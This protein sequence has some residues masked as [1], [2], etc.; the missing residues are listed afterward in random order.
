MGRSAELRLRGSRDRLR[1][2]A[3]LS[4]ALK[5]PALAS[6][7]DRSANT[8][9]QTSVVKKSG[10]SLGG[11]RQRAEDLLAAQHER[12]EQVEAHLG[13]Q[14]QE[15]SD[16]VIHEVNERFRAEREELDRRSAELAAQGREL[17]R[18]W[19]EQAAGEQRLI[20]RQE[21]LKGA[22]SK[23]PRR[24]ANRRNRSNA[25]PGR[26]SKQPRNCGASKRS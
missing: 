26:T 13:S 18:R 11:K 25:P 3:P 2:R 21:E 17:D 24:S 20:A 23:S 10:R 5:I 1:P 14:L 12:L 16:S 19:E 4:V 9:G 15:L 22:K 7:D 8:D 6:M